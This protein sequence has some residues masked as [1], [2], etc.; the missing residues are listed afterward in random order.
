M[1]TG[2]APRMVGRGEVFWGGK[3][4]GV[5]DIVQMPG[6]RAPVAIIPL[7]GSGRV[8]KYVQGGPN[9]YHVLDCRLE[10]ER[11]SPY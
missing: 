9:T 11:M 2:S 8:E 4:M 3:Q 10:T 7:R 6:Y 1:E 5:F